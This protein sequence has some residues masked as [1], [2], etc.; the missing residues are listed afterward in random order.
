MKNLPRTQR[1][2]DEEDERIILQVLSKT[3][4]VNFVVFLTCQ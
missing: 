3:A 1:V 4:I 2:V